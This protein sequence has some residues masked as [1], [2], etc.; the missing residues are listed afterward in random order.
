VNTRPAIAAGRVW[1]HRFAGDFPDFPG[2][3]ARALPPA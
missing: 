2:P 3:R 1:Q